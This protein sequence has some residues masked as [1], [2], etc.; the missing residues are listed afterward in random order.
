MTEAKPIPAEVWDKKDRRIVR[1]NAVT[2]AVAVVLPT[3]SNKINNANDLLE[4]VLEIAG[5]IEKWVYRD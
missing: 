5:K 3:V 4:L 1:M 2:N